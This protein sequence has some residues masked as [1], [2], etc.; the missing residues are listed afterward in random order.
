VFLVLR[1]LCVAIC[2]VTAQAIPWVEMA[3]NQKNRNSKE[4]KVV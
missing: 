2:V 1:L 4:E 3:S